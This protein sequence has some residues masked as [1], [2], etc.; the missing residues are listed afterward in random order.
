MTTSAELE[1]LTLAAISVIRAPG[2]A[3]VISSDHPIPEVD[4]GAGDRPDFDLFHF[5]FSICSHKV[6]TVL[7]ELGL[8]YGSNQFAGPTIY[9]NYTPEYVRLRL[10]SDAARNAPFV[11]G[12]SGGS[13]VE[14]EG[15]DPLVV[16]TLVDHQEGRVLAD[17]KLICLAL[18]R[19][20]RD[21]AD[22]L[23]EALEPRII[24]QMD[25]V[26]RTPHVAL[27][28]GADPGGDTRPSEVQARMPGI[29]G[30]K[31]DT[32]NG[33][34]RQV[35]D[36]PELVEAYRAKLAKEKAAEQFVVDAGAMAQAVALAEEL[37]AGL[38]TDLAASGGPWLFG[39]DITLADLMWG[40][41]L[42]RLDYLGKQSF[43]ADRPRVA[44]YVERLS[45]RPSLKA[46]VLDWPGSRKRLQKRLNGEKTSFQGMKGVAMMPFRYAIEPSPPC[47]AVGDRR[48]RIL[49]VRRRPA[50]H[51][52]ARG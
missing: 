41:S 51:D 44:A 7:A 32:I 6:R 29:H 36:E 18:A 28:Y 37:V 3:T 4:R 35:S 24:A 17:S 10:R 45:G 19:S 11:S 48:S 50:G 27:L 1:R 31:F 5:G 46:A 52:P 30:I 26:D 16:P 22:L 33:H 38:E 49:P 42:L 9:E 39:A 8:S 25:A 2:R 12:Y 20:H 15:F 13:S 14:T 21:V 40:V 34:M 47:P 23:P 43:W